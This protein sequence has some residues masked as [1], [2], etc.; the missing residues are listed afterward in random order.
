MLK[1]PGTTNIRVNEATHVRIRHMAAALRLRHDLK[2]TPTID[3]VIC[4]GLDALSA[5]VP[6]AAGNKNGKTAAHAEAVR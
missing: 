6:L 1:Q 5:D 3:D 2:K 4:A